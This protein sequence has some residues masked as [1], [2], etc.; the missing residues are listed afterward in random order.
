MNG[1]NLNACIQAVR[2]S[3][4]SPA[5][6]E[7]T[8]SDKF[9]IPTN[10][11]PISDFVAQVDSLSVVFSSTS[12]DIDGSISSLLWNFG[13]GNTSTDINPI[14]IYSSA[15]DYTVT[16]SVTDNEG[17]KS[18][19]TTKIVTISATPISASFAM[20]DPSLNS[21]IQVD[22]QIAFAG[23]F[24]V[25]HK[26][27]TTKKQD[28]V[29]YGSKKSEYIFEILGGD[30]NI[31]AS[32]VA[33]T[34]SLDLVNIFDGLLHVIK[35]S[36]RADV[37]RLYV[38]GIVVGYANITA[39][40]GIASYLVGSSVD[41]SNG[42]YGCISESVFVNLHTPE[43]F[44]FIFNISSSGVVT[45]QE[46][47]ATATYINIPQ[48][49][50]ESLTLNGE[51]YIGLD[52][53]D[54]IPQYT[55]I[56][57]EVAYGTV[58]LST[59]GF[60]LLESAIYKCSA[61]TTLVENSTEECHFNAVHYR[62]ESPKLLPNINEFIQ[63]AN[64]STHQSQLQWG[65]YPP[66]E[67]VY[68]SDFKIQRIMKKAIQSNA[69]APFAN[70][71]IDFAGNSGGSGNLNASRSVGF[72]GD[73]TFLWEQVNGSGIAIPLNDYTIESPAFTYPHVEYSQ[74]ST[75]K[76][77]VTEVSSG[78][79]VSSY[80][81][82]A[83]LPAKNISLQP[84][85][86][87]IHTP[88]ATSRL[89]Y[90]SDSVGDDATA[91][92]LSLSEVVDPISPQVS[93]KPYKTIS[94]AMAQVREGFGDWVVLKRGDTWLN[95][96]FG[97][98]GLSGESISNPTI[99]GYYG[100]TGD[101]PKILTPDG[102]GGMFIN[103]RA[104]S[105]IKIIGLHLYA[106]TADPDAPTYV[107]GGIGGA[108]ISLVGSGSDIE[109]EDCKLTHFN[110]AYKCNGFDG[111]RYANISLKRCILANSYRIDGL[112]H[113]SGAYFENIDGLT[114]TENILYENGWRD[115]T[116]KGNATRYNH[117]IY[118][119]YNCDGNL[120]KCSRNVIAKASS[121]GIHGRCG[122]VYEDNLYTRNPISQQIGFTTAPLKDGV[123]GLARDNVIIDGEPMDRYDVGY[124][125][126]S[127]AIWGLH[128]ETDFADNG[129]HA[130]L[131]NN[132]VANS[133][134]FGSS[135]R[136]IHGMN[137]LAAVIET[138]SRRYNWMSLNDNLDP[139]WLDPSRDIG[140]YMGSI[141]E[142]ATEDEYMNQ[143]LNRPLG[144]WDARLYPLAVNEYIR[145]GFNL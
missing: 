102:V 91:I 121:H 83:V 117:N 77:T 108:G 67:G 41:I 101:R 106:H 118:I 15:G 143:C 62:S 4:Q 50:I 126:T 138:N 144:A 44:T 34:I 78:I 36:L 74:V 80:V 112:G 43:T 17:L 129:G 71:G 128:V 123:V 37:L 145:K 66:S 39:F 76:L 57:N 46:S 9:S 95:Q 104:A 127:A 130:V 35:F 125:G 33:H 88:S 73:V 10:K 61:T 31:W 5:P 79:P 81:K 21:Y 109:V 97:F 42:F 86:L 54:G 103:N 105:F 3:F 25:I 115:G 14:H 85:E 116:P 12:T 64:A 140:K 23:D 7:R 16:L 114:I 13:D 6:L 136:D 111:G 135:M 18:N 60:S 32:G 90:V 94:A 70:A 119:Q 110:Y 100:T 134:R 1:S 38:D 59:S 58:S 55:A 107:V 139:D 24:D 20:L 27:A 53:Y 93:V 30:I 26:I 11:K 122:G 124:D 133:T 87:S 141:G 2:W 113:S 82:V 45:T 75:F 69:G 142:V 8:V 48:S 96:T 131:D 56:A 120:L 47:N 19:E 51:D 49:N 132:V 84:S 65:K 137:N 72:T 68:F 28:M 99:Y 98:I 52:L 63:K 29:I 92:P 22:Q 89:I 40:K